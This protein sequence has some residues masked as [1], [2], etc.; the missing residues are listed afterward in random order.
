MANVWINEFHYD[1]SAA[2]DPNEF[3]EIAGFVGTNLNGWKIQLYNGSNGQVYHTFD[4][5]GTI[6]GPSESAFGFIGIDPPSTNFIQNGG[7]DGIALIDAAGN[8]VEFLS[9]EG[10]F[11]ATDGAA[12]GM[13]S[14]NIGAFENGGGSS[15]GSLQ[16]Q[17]VGYD[18]EDFDLWT[19]FSAVGTATKGDVNTGQTFE[20]PAGQSLRISADTAITE[21][22]DGTTTVTFTVTR[23]NPGEDVTFDWSLAGLGQD[24]WA[25]TDDFTGPTS[26]SFTFTGTRTTYDI[27]VT[28][29]TDKLYELNER[30]SVALSNVTPG[31]TVIQSSA[32]TTIMNDDPV[33]IYDIQGS[34][35][36]AARNNQVVMTTGIITGIQ[37]IGESRGFYIQDATGDGNTATSDGIF[38]FMGS[39]WIP[40][41][42]VGDEVFVNGKVTEFNGLTQIT[43][44]SDTIPVTVSLIDRGNALPE[45]VLI[46]P[47]GIT[48]PTDTVANA[49]AFYEALEGMRVTVEPTRVVGATNNFGEVYTVIEG[50]YDSDSLNDRGGLSI[51]EEG[52]F[53]P[54]RIQFD[55]IRDSLN[56]PMVDVGARLGAQTG[57]MSYGF[58]NYEVLISTTPVV[59][60]TSN[61]Q[62]EVTSVTR[63]NEFFLTFGNYNVENLDINDDDG[64]ADIDGGQFAAVANQIVNNLGAPAVL[65]LQ[66][67]QDDSGSVDN[68]VTSSH[69][70]LQKLVDYIKAA[71]GPE[72]KFAYLEPVNNKD[73]G[74]TGG[75]IRQAFLYN[76]DVV[77]FVAGSLKRIVDDQP[78]VDGDAFEASRKPLVAQFDFQGERYTFINNHLNSKSGD[79][80]IFGTTQPPVLRSQAQRIE[81]AKII[82]AYVDELL[83]NPLTQ[84]VVVLGDLND[85]SWSNPLKTLDGTIN[86]GQQV[87]WNMAEDFIADPR[88]RTDYI[89]EGNSQS[90]DHIYV[91]AAL[92]ARMEAFDIV[93]I[94]SEFDAN[95]QVS[96]HD[97]L[98]ARSTFKVTRAT[99]NN[100]NIGGDGGSNA[101]IGTGSANVLLGGAG[102]DYLE[103]NAGDDILLGGEGAD[104]LYGG[105]GIDYV[106]YV[107]ATSG[108]TASLD[109]P[110]VNTGEAAGDTYNSIENMRGS[111]FND[112]LVGNMA[113]NLIDGDAGADVLQGNGGNDTYIVDNALDRIIEAMGGGTDTVRTS[114]SFTLAAGTE[115]E[116]LTATGSGSID[117][118]GNAFVNTITGTA[119][120]NVIDGGAGADRM[121]GREGDDT[122]IVDNA[123]DVVT[124]VA[125]GGSDTI[126][127]SVS[128]ALGSTTDVERLNATGAA[129]VSLT[130]NAL[131]NTITG[132]AGANKIYGGL[133]NDILRGG[134]GKDTFVF[135]TKANNSTNVDRIFDFSVRDDSIY[136]DNKVFTKL[137]S[138]SASKPKKFTSDMFIKGAKAQDREDRIVYDNKTG[139]LYYDQDGTGA[140]A[141]VKIGTLNKSLSLTHSDF[142]VI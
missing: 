34:G 140:K 42:E 96:D 85:F 137:G 18:S 24:G 136:L 45:A 82:N 129:N 87:L 115:V 130:G 70:T 117:L 58:S 110:L 69:K 90:L 108:V 3:I 13:D 61:L 102:R 7:P 138:G 36:T 112:T 121:A 2:N 123:D 135:D 51:S 93:R 59:T 124:E 83:E 21:G 29:S 63:P 132:N 79:G 5:T 94:N 142:F 91:S 10:A 14:T 141:Q 64:D 57:I 48:P 131:I 95:Q 9:Y 6:Q 77:D 86:S 46:G 71:G 89:Y 50:A 33:R 122:Y 73:G 74:Q 27:T 128:F 119:A 101:L 55:N 26:G 118:T 72:Y 22:S 76:D 56:M 66:E 28:V 35:L 12:A 43:K 65:A 4:L 139:A 127:T 114:I 47:N 100:P 40:N 16:R 133:G 109:A 113:S 126:Q 84:N 38:V 41:F 32:T 107:G 52:D 125:G 88:N 25:S 19:A 31:V 60:Q 105:E 92:R 49:I 37:M 78:T 106:S 39:D 97:A 15:T 104:G 98:V 17:G 44:V 30:F 23:F 116:V 62:P 81:Q 80:G 134:S 99:I 1:N 120:G 75:N 11:K 67:V 53:N 8:V 68:G 111:A 54:E 20:L 103:G